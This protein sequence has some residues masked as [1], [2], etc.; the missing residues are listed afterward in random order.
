MQEVKPSSD[1]RILLPAEIRQALDLHEGE[2]L[3]WDIVD[4]EV[5]LSTRRARLAKARRL[6]A[7]YLAEASTDDFLAARHLRETTD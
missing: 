4:G 5:R 3:Q 7:P 2:S 6:A 1:G